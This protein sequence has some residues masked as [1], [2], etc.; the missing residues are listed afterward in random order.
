MSRKRNSGQTRRTGRQ[1]LTQRIIDA[2]GDN[3]DKTFNYKQM[4]ALLGIKSEAQRLLVGDIM[5]E[6][7]DEDFIIREGRGKYKLNP[8][9]GYTEGTI[10]R[11]GVKMYLRPDDG[12]EPIFIPERKTRHGLSGD[13][14]KVYL[15]AR[16]KGQEPEGKWWKYSN[17]RATRSWAC[18]T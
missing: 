2:F 18:S 10:E 7:C 4:S 14:A 11:H 15:Y 1:E 12:G 3:H 9:G 6:L 5:L 8:R 17:A 13:R 16:R